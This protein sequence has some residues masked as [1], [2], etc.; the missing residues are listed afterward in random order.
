MIGQTARSE[1]LPSTTM[2]GRTDAGGIIE[3]RNKAL[4]IRD[5]NGH[6]DYLIGSRLG[7]GWVVGTPLAEIGQ[8]DGRSVGRRSSEELMMD[9]DMFMD[10]DMEV[11]TGI[12]IG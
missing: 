9:L 11:L 12:R 3:W 4:Q 2:L 7:G 10:V 6:V 5:G 8:V 1:G